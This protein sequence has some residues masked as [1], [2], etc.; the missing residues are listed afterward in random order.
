MIFIASYSVKMKTPEESW[1][2]LRNRVKMVH[3]D[4]IGDLR[5]ARTD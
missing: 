5:A 4:H 2:R 3:F 1:M